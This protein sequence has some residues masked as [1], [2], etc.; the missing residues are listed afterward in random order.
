MES[1][2]LM[3]RMVPM[4]LM[5]SMESRAVLVLWGH[6]VVRGYRGPSG[7]LVVL[8]PK[9]RKDLSAREVAKVRKVFRAILAQLELLARK[10]QL[11]LKESKAYQ[12]QQDLLGYP[13]L[14]VQLSLRS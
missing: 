14:R 8:A 10:E 1:M 6:K 5:E 2:E 7:Q 13:G 12:V 3:A 4:G 9:E 11:D